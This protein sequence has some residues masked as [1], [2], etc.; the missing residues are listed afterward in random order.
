MPKTQITLIEVFQSEKD[1]FSLMRSLE[2]PRSAKNSINSF[3]LN[4]LALVELIRKRII[5]KG[6][7][8][9]FPE[10]KYKFIVTERSS[11][12]DSHLFS[13]HAISQGWGL[14]GSLGPA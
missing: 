14:R 13:R 6:I 12:S 8:N 2:A 9:K 5:F 11:Q 10:H 3:T 7:M 4:S 1:F